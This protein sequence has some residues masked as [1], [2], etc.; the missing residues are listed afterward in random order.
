[1]KTLRAALVLALRPRRRRRAHAVQPDE[2]LTDPALE[3]RARA[4]SSEL[5]CLVCQNQSIDD[6]DAPLAHDIRVLIRERIAKGESNDAVRAFLVSRYGDFILL[7]A[8]VRAETLLLWLSA[9]LTLA[10]GALGDLGRDAPPA[11]AHARPERRRRRAPRRA[12]AR[13]RRDLRPARQRSRAGSDRARRRLDGAHGSSSGA[14]SPSIKA[15]TSSS[16]S[17]SSSRNGSSGAASSSTS[18]SSR[19]GSTAF[20][21]LASTS[22]SETSS[23]PAGCAASSSSSS[24]LAVARSDARGGALEDRAA[25]RANDRVFVQIE[26]LGAAVLALALRSELGF[27]HGYV[28]LVVGRLRSEA[29]VSRRRR[30]CQCDSASEVDSARRGC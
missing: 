17:S 18:M 7:E 26:E 19:T 1:M 30:P 14:M 5:R 4:L 23:T 28:S 13:P 3:A 2:V 11:R 20:S 21:S 15:V 22:S 8:A 9:P 24:S 16:S 29:S 6:S 27:G 12:V 10:L 25:F